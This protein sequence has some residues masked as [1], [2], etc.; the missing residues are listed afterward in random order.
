MQ[1]M[2]YFRNPNGRRWFF[3]LALICLC[4]NIA[5]RAFGYIDLAPTIARI[6]GDAQKIS[7]IEVTGFNESTHALTMKEVRALKGAQ[8]DPAIVHNVASLDGN[9]VPPSIVQWAE[10]GARGVLFSTR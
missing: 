2:T 6:I 1:N 7:V 4:V 10:T 3:G 5:G 8:A 9:V